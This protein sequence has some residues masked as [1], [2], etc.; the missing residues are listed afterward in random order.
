MSESNQVGHNP[1]FTGD[2]Q[3]LFHCVT[4]SIARVRAGDRTSRHLYGHIAQALGELNA[5]R[6]D[7]GPMPVF[8][9]GSAQPA[10]L[11]AVCEALSLAIA[12]QT[13][14]VNPPTGANWLLIAQLLFQLVQL[15]GEKS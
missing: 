8:A 14:S 15:L 11:D 1:P 3:V 6:P 4:D 13:S 2:T 9:T 7:D 5:L 12:P 10:D